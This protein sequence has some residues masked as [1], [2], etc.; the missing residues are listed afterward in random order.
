[1]KEFKQQ[2][3]SAIVEKA[4]G[5]KIV[6][7]YETAQELGYKHISSQDCRDI[8]GAVKKSIPDYTPVKMLDHQ[9][10]RNKATASLFT[11]L[12]FVDKEL[13]F[14]DGAEFYEND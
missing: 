5:C 4:R 6:S 7:L 1:M 9:Q 12:C 11:T 10:Y 8:L 2:I 13:E 14:D 3:I